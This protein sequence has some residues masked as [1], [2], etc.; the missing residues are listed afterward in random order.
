ML[1]IRP[2]QVSD[3]LLIETMIKE[4]AEYE[5]ATQEVKASARDIELHLSQKQPPFECLIAEQDGLAAGFAV[6]FFAYST[7]E[8]K[9]TLYLEDLFVRP[10]YRGSR[11]GLALMSALAEIAQKRSCA[12]FEWSV[13]TWNQLAINFYERIGASR[14]EGWTRYRLS[15]G[16]IAA[17][18]NYSQRAAV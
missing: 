18:A 13:L 3:A 6:Y 14:I 15:E 11:V 4:L 8:G 16:N 12:R 10:L 2:A 5:K 1:N 17:L 9:A 7:W